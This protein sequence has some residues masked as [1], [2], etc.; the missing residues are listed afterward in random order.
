MQKGIF[1]CAENKEEMRQALLVEVLGGYLRRRSIFRD[2]EVLLQRFKPAKLVHRD[3]ELSFL[4]SSLAPSLRG[5]KPGNIFLYGNT[6]TGKTAACEFVGRELGAASAKSRQRAM[7]I[8]INCKLGK[9]ADT[10]Y[11]LIAA[12]TSRL[13]KDLPVTGLPTDVVYNTFF[14]LLEKKGKTVILVLDEIDALLFKAGDGFLYS[15]TRINERLEKSQVSI[16]GISNNLTV[17][18]YFDPRIK[19]SLAAE[20]FVFSPYDAVQLQDI[21]RDRARVAF[22]DGVL[23]DGV[24]E[25][26]SAIAAQEHGDARKA[27]NILKLAGEVAESM[28]EER[29]GEEHVALAKER[30]ETDHL[31][32]AINTQ[33]RQGKAVISALMAL[34]ERGTKK[35]TTGDLYA[36]YGE[37]CQR[38]SLAPLTQRRVSDIIGELQ[39]QGI[40]NARIVNNGR[41]GR[42]RLLELSPDIEALGRSA[43]VP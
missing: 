12:L 40:I 1:V 19:S 29:I 16:V 25:L 28:G 5:E 23:D 26:C 39:M 4:A 43:L 20:E 30:L 17:F 14:S 35:A 6:G 15:L 22:R 24:I 18:D 21:L 8:N 10:E 34:R 32:T 13:G 11:R 41:Y 38:F 9:V 2:K 36:A 42:T 7:V 37:S 27:L 33:P 3:E 31:T